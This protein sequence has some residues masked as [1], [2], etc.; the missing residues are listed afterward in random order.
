MILVV[1]FF[2]FNNS[3]FES[4]KQKGMFHYATAQAETTPVPQDKNDDAADDPAI[5]IHS[6]YPDS[7][8]I[9]GTDKKGGL[10]VYDLKG[11]ELFYYADGLMN[12]VDLR[13]QFA[14]AAD[15]IDILAA[16]NRT[17]NSISLYSVNL[18]GSLEKI[19]A[20]E[21]ITEMN[22]EVYGLCMYRSPITG[23]FYVF[24]NNKEGVVEQWELFANGNNVDG[25]IVRKLKLASQLEGMVAD[26]ETAT[27]FVG[28]ERAGIWKF[29]AE[30]DASVEGTLLPMSSESD[31]ENIQF[32]IEGLTIYYLPEGKGYLIASSQ[33]NNSYAVFQREMPHGYLNSFRIA[34]GIVDGVEGTDG[35]DVTSISLGKSFPDGL[36]VIQDGSNKNDGKLAPQNFKLVRW[37][38]VAAEFTPPL[39]IR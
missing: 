33:G 20:R 16:T 15:T 35:F 1:G 8:R 5:W 10:A 18:N 13:Y 38:S 19:H 27:L 31:N 23:K 6:T 7:S 24:I 25:R 26:D 9:I 22:D 2:L 21:L 32:D 28:E 4:E 11:E 3:T 36:L 12:N 14:L 39:K 37:G 17:N 34:D 30:P 29:N